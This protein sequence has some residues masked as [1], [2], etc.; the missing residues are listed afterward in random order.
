MPHSIFIIYHFFFGT[1]GF[2]EGVLP[3]VSLLSRCRLSGFPVESAILFGPGLSAI[4][5]SFN[6]LYIQMY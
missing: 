2:N 1:G 6:W 4:I 3:G 5:L